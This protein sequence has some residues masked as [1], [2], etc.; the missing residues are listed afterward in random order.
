MFSRSCSTLKAH[1]AIGFA[2][3][4]R[5]K[6]AFRDKLTP[7]CRAALFQLVDA[8]VLFRRNY[9]RSDADIDFAQ[10]L[11][12]KALVRL[13]LSFP[14]TLHTVTVHMLTHMG[15][16]LKNFGPA[17][18][19]MNYAAEHLGGV[20]V[21]NLFSV[22]RY[23][24]ECIKLSALREAITLLLWDWDKSSV[25]TDDSDANYTQDHGLQFMTMC[26][27]D[28]DKIILGATA[29]SRIRPLR[30]CLTVAEEKQWLIG[31]GGFML[32]MLTAWYQTINLDLQTIQSRFQMCQRKYGRKRITSWK[33]LLA[34][35]GLPNVRQ[36]R[37]TAS[38]KDILV[39]C[40]DKAD[41]FLN[42]CT[43]FDSIRLGR[44]KMLTTD[45]ENISR[46]PNNSTCYCSYVVGRPWHPDDDWLP[47]W[48][49]LFQHPDRVTYELNG[50]P[51]DSVQVSYGRV[52]LFL[53]L[54]NV[55]YAIV[56]HVP[57]LC[58][59]DDANAPQ[60]DKKY[61]APTHL[62]IAYFDTSRCANAVGKRL[63]DYFQIEDMYRD[64]G[65]PS[66]EARNRYDAAK[67][68][69][70]K[71]YRSKKGRE[72]AMKLF[73]SL[74]YIDEQ[75]FQASLRAFVECADIFDDPAA[76]DM[77]RA[78]MRSAVLK[79]FPYAVPLLDAYVGRSTTSTGSGPRPDPCA[80][81]FRTAPPPLCS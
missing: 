12:N 43:F 53:E 73:T 25:G 31:Q 45:W 40:E 47:E 80:I 44:R 29:M 32:G 15:E 71:T 2:S 54:D 75:Y 38:Q 66:G 23:G 14:V 18:G 49:Q 20:I 62:P 63:A 36:L 68:F 4:S 30:L 61:C 64:T 55:V 35:D 50:S 28:D 81:S 74:G 16:Y 1:D 79:V 59:D 11:M 67:T 9:F 60:R 21:R 37:W 65:A 3:G 13:Q 70:H 39:S 69:V 33:S 5:L 56:E 42:K 57:L 19:I 48:S 51:D 34:L 17:R 77:Q 22:H 27:E 72:K 58:M 10:E 78:D 26:S 7:K 52:H 8:F 76:V 24:A 46:Y 41:F 6:Y